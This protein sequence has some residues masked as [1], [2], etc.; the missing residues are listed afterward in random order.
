[1]ILGKMFG[2]LGYSETV[3]YFQL[4]AIAVPAPIHEQQTNP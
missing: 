1:M 3:L 2:H 4:L